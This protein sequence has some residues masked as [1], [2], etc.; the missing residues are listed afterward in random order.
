MTQS[1]PTIGKCRLCGEE[2]ELLQ[3]H[4]IP[5]FVIEW[6]K[7]T[8]ATGFLRQGIDRNR[9]S[10]D[11]QRFRLLCS[12][13]EKRLSVWEKRFAEEIFRPFHAGELEPLRYDDWL[14]KFVVSVSWRGF[15][16]THHL[17]RGARL[18]S[19]NKV[20]DGWREYLL[21]RAPD[22]GPNTHHLFLAGAVAQAEIEL[23]RDWNFY[24]M[25]SVD[26]TPAYSQTEG[27]MYTNL[28][29]IILCSWFEPPDPPGFV[30]T[31]VYA[32]GIIDEDQIVHHQGFCEFAFN[33]VEHVRSMATTLSRRQKEVMRRSL[34][35]D[36]QRLANSESLRIVQ[37]DQGLNAHERGPETDE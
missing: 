35:R 18:L 4:V 19:W 14:L 31:K 24:R 21:E 36:L 7:S 25:R 22:P 37:L 17:P 15:I 12:E 34:S 10:Q 29:G 6:L 8:S 3:S 20:A 2:R 32:Q 5:K 13:C 28:P 11:I 26:M 30:N 9:R 33:R 1:L 27:F 16:V 23:P